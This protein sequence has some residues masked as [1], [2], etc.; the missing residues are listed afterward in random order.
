MPSSEAVVDVEV[1]KRYIGD[2]EASITEFLGE[3]R[4]ALR[5]HAAELER[6]VT[7]RDVASVSHTAHTL[8][9]TARAAGAT[10]FGDLLAAM[11]VAAKQHD[12]EAIDR[13]HEEFQRM[14]PL[15]MQRLDV[16]VPPT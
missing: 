8:K 14:L 9:S 5:H 10:A 4:T 2:D 6:G 7:S 16:L 11:E 15:V 12:L 13:Y 1:L 3:F